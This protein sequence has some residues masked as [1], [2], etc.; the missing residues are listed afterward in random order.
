MNRRQF[1]GAVASV[2][3]VPAMATRAASGDEPQRS[4][5]KRSVAMH[6]KRVR[7]ATWKNHRG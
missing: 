4:E 3:A 5:L 7:R 1:G 6:L 2:V